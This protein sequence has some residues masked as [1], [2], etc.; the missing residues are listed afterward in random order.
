M[1]LL[2]PWFLVGAALIAG[3]I[4]AH[5]IRRATRERLTF[6]ALQFLDTSP[7]RL[8]RRSRVQNPWLLALR[9]LIVAILAFGF[10][11]PFLRQD[12]P[13]VAGSSVVRHVVAVLD[14]SAS[15]QRAGLAEAAH[16]RIATLVST[17]QPADQFVLLSAGHRVTELVSA[18]QWLVTAPADRPALVRAV[19]DERNPGW[20]PT[21]LDSAAEAA[22]ARWEDMTELASDT[23][24][25]RELVLFSDFGAGA[26]LSGL[27][28]L[29]W[30][31]N[32]QVVLETVTPTVAGNA[33]LHWLGWS[34]I[35]ESEVSARVRVSRSFDAPESLQLQW[36]DARTGAALGNPE[37]LTLLPGATEVRLLPLPENAPTA[38]QL[39]LTG[40]AQDYDNR[41]WLV[42]AAPREIGLHYLGTH[43]GGDPQHAR[44]YIERAVAGWR[45]PVARV[46]SGLP[47]TDSASGLFVVA[48]PLDTNQLSAVR[49]R[50][51]NGAFALVLLADASMVETAAALAGETGWNPAVPER[52][53]A[54]LGQLDFQHPLFAPF[55]DP[56]YS[57]FT[58]IRFWQP[59]SLTLPADSKAVVVA[60]FEEGSPAVLEAPVGRGRLIVWGGD[61]SPAASQWVLSSKFVPWLQ[62]LAERAAG[63]V[64]RTSIAEIGDAARL[65]AG[66]AS[67]RWKHVSPSTAA[68]TNEET[69]SAPG[70]YE[71]TED[72]ETREVALLVPAAESNTQ[73]LALDTWEQLGVPLSTDDRNEQ[74][75]AAESSALPAQSAAALE[76]RQQI[77]RWLLWVAVALL[78][79]ESAASFLVSKRRGSAAS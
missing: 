62:A 69:P 47:P 70:L 54:M 73:A 40:D 10:A 34:S 46:H 26:R 58:R 18:G 71:L 37:P 39:E 1:N 48:A 72:G 49:S 2:A 38:V 65:T 43:A 13:A 35:E 63:G 11:R 41:L 78:A 24:A 9:C 23:S 64:G 42:R 5:L 19:L 15:M 20:G 45:E 4:I 79:I 53:D 31:N 14:E 74:T 27:A 55:A 60:R 12:T 59:Q 33:S 61:W 52:A 28:N 25:R 51:E 32:A 3:P 57:D 17:L 29:D 6:S 75:R 50:L 56:L 36:R 30:P 67:P 77:W 68:T 44:F 21:P 7:P 76:S 66:T 22:L 16:E 8:D